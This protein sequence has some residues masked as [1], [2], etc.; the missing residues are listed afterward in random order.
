MMNNKMERTW[1]VQSWYLPGTT[2]GNQLKKTTKD[3]M[4]AETENEKLL[5]MTQKH[6]HFDHFVRDIFKSV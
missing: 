3:T 5:N 4:S 2:E 1:K 6:H